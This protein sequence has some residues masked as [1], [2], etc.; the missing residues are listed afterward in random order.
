MVFFANKFL[1]FFIKRNAV[2]LAFTHTAHLAFK[3][4]VAARAFFFF[5]LAHAPVE[6]EKAKNIFVASGL[7]QQTMK[8]EIKLPATQCHL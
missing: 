8:D 7:V 1:F 5:M 3:G 6:F 4:F 2:T